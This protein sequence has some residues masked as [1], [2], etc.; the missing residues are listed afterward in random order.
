MFI[1]VQ[2]EEGLLGVEA[3]RGQNLNISPNAGKQVRGAQREI[4]D[5]K[6]GKV[7]KTNKKNIRENT[8][9]TLERGHTMQIKQNNKGTVAV[10]DAIQSNFMHTYPFLIQRTKHPNCENT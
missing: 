10:Q 3:G 4:Q 2:R 6:T 8:K 1:N 7:Q 9:G 5:Q